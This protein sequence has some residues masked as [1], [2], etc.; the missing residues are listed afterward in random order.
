MS[1][2]VSETLREVTS[3]LDDGRYV[4]IGTLKEGRLFLAEKAGK[5]FVLKTAAGARGLELLK[6][7]YELSIGLSHPG[8]AYVFTYEEDSPVGPC[9]VQEYVDGETLDAWLAKKPGTKERK[10]VLRELLS[11]VA[12][13]HQKGIVHN[14]LKPSNILIARS[15]GALKLID[16]GFADDDGHVQKTLGG[17]RG[18]ASPELIDGKQVDARSD[19]YSLGRLIQDLFPG[20]YRC[21]ARRCLRT[22][23]ERRYS[24]VAALERAFKRRLL[25]LQITLAAAV[26]ALL[27]W[28]FFRQPAMVEVPVI[29]EV[30]SDSLRSVVD[31][32]QGII[33]RREQAEAAEQSAL[34]D[35]KARVE[36]VYKRV[37]PPYRQALREA[38]STQEA[39]QAWITLNEKLKEVNFDIPAAAPEAVRPALRDY[40]IERNNVLLPA[41]NEE[42][43]ARIRELTSSN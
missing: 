6:R 40:I 34:A 31:S 4:V 36:A 21:I 26:A 24:S 20:R 42:L 1:E 9:I 38:Q 2:L 16:L 13:L 8:L 19:I 15:G 27:L 14:D 25:P 3:G 7:E 39:T 10:R 23:P 29:M 17:T 33:T 35:A 11:V 30:E 43:T 22:E 41:L 37:V 5:R 28:P 18:Y 12:C 32:L